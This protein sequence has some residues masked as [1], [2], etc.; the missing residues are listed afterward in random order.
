MRNNHKSLLP[1][2]GAL[3][4][5]LGLSGC[6]AQG[7]CPPCYV[8]DVMADASSP[9][10]SPSSALYVQLASS[11]GGKGPVAEVS[12]TIKS[13]DGGKETHTYSGDEVA[14]ISAS[15]M[16]SIPDPGL[17]DVDGHPPASKA[18][19]TISFTSG[20]SIS[21][22]IDVKPAGKGS[23]GEKPGSEDKP[24]DGV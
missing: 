15:S 4:L 5:L 11:D 20:E 14:G 19:I 2:L 21:D 23:G 13:P 9:D 8:G 1:A 18:D 16:V 6:P 10:A 7:G 24:R 3:G 22:T 17:Y 12:V